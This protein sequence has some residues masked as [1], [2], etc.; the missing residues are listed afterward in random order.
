MAY[1]Q[2]AVDA[3]DCEPFVYMPAWWS[4]FLFQIISPRQLAIY[5]YIA[6]LGADGISM[7]TVKQIQQDMGLASDSMVYDALRGL[8]QAS[9]IR[10]VRVRAD[11]GRASQNGYQRPACESTLIALLEN[12]R[13][14]YRLRPT[15]PQAG[16]QSEDVTDLARKGLQML[17]GDDFLRY[18]SA[19]L[20]QRRD[21]L[22]EMLRDSLHR[23]E[24]GQD[25]SCSRAEFN[26]QP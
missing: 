19:A 9:L 18:E 12:G 23:R 7:P 10:R 15:L 24:R 20:A 25:C 11:G 13:I 22:L 26:P 8:E 5:T 16:P 3:C 17:L 1:P 4:S 14:D 6:M 21:V 2:P